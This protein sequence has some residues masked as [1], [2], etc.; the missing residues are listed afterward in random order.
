MVQNAPGL[1][2]NYLHQKTGSQ[3]VTVGSTVAAGQ[4]LAQTGD[5]GVPS[6][7]GYHLH[8]VFANVGEAQVGMMATYPV[9]FSDYL[10]SNDYGLTWFQ[11]PRGVPTVGQWLRRAN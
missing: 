2:G 3:A 9:A 7:G 11:M 4:T 1:V 10:V 5:V 8:L 6:C